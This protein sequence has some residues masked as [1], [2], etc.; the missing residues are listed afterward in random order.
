MKI[1]ISDD[2]KN[3]YEICNHTSKNVLIIG[4]AGTG[5]STFL[6]YFVSHTN[7]NVAVLAP[8]GISAINVGGVT[9][10]SFFG[11]K[12]NITE[13]NIPIIPARKLVLYQSLDTIIIDEISMVR[14]DI[15]DCVD[16]FL[17]RNLK[18]NKPFAGIQMI[19]IGDLYQLPPVV[20]GEDERRFFC[21]KY[22]S[23]Y[24]FDSRVFKEANFELI[25]FEK[26]YRQR[27]KKFIEILNR[28]R[29]NTAT[30]EDLEILNQRVG[31]EHPKNSYPV[32]L[33]PHNETAKKINE[34]RI[35]SLSNKIYT[36]KAK[37]SGNFEKDSFPAD[38]E[39]KISV[40]SQVMFLNNDLHSRWVNGIIG[41]VKKID[42]KTE[43]ITV[44]T[45]NNDLV[46]VTKNEWEIFKYIFDEKEKKLRTQKTG[47]F[48]QFPLKLAWALTI[49]KSQGKTFDSVTIDL[50]KS[51]FEKGQLYVA[52]SRAKKLEGI[53]LTHP[54]KKSYIMVDTRIVKFLTEYRYR[55]YERKISYQEKQRII[56]DAIKN[57]K[58]LKILY[59]KP[60]DEKTIRV[61][62][63]ISIEKRIF[64]EKEVE[65]VVAL[66]HSKNEHRFFKIERILD[67]SIS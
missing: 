36:F 10:H 25:E 22:S 32:I 12:P 55:T 11:F 44:L 42:E 23:Q 40:D 39:L 27:D 64:N 45:E 37:F 26:V 62:T 54:I 13:E 34:E 49:H 31:K 15:L 65:G 28:I 47:Y 53:S 57:S 63:P 51:I 41:I 19:L 58:K 52:L 8:T 38:E 35:R 6:K 67:L 43:V 48:I 2:F 56:L 46:N 16:I 5:K 61:I 59:L 30:E 4:K 50:S 60:N 18:I 17:R 29:N 20:K 21:E 66:C 3:A 33:T 24:F 1:E 9:L 7:K 14:A